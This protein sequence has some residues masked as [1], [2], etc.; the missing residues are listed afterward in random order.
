MSKQSYICKKCCDS[1]P[2]SLNL[3]RDKNPPVYCHFQDSNADWRPVERIQITEAPEPVN[4]L[5]IP[6]E[7]Q[8]AVD[9]GLWAK[10]GSDVI[11]TERKGQF[12]QINAD[13][14]VR[15]VDNSWIK[16]KPATPTAEELQERL[17]RI[18]QYLG[19]VSARSTFASAHYTTLLSI[20]NGEK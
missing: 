12:T 16:Q 7:L 10:N 1:G 3:P 9:S 11:I 6:S 5:D 17:N 20:A 14:L 19:S 4:V 8:Y 2:C 15:V 18:E 13:G